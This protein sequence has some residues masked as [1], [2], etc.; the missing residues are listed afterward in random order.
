[1]FDTVLNALPAFVMYFTVAIAI[2]TAFLAIYALIT[3]YNEMELICDGNTAAAISLSGTVI[4][5]AMPVA[6]A[7]I[8]SHN[9]YAMLA[10]GVIACVVQLMVFVVARLAMPRL[11]QDIPDGK[12]STAIFLAGLS[13]GVGIINAASIL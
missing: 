1:M 4:G 8:T 2:L 9:V 3:P 7:I 12:L 13:I 10:W 6:V 5:I 11:V